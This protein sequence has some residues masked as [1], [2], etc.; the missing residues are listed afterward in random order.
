VSTAEHLDNFYEK[1]DNHLNYISGAGTEAYV[2]LDSNIDLLETD[3]NQQCRDY[4]DIGI[5]N[6]FV[7]LISAGS[8]IFP[9]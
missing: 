3:I 6:G 5:S 9:Y 2:F 7:Q 4:V 8:N 1:L